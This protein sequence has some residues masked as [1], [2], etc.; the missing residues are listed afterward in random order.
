MPQVKRKKHYLDWITKRKRIYFA[1]LIGSEYNGDIIYHFKKNQYF[2]NPAIL[3]TICG[4]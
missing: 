2:S 3:K 1:L 4:Y